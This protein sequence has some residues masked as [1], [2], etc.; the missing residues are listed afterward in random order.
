M[1]WNSC[2]P[3]T[4]QSKTYDQLCEIMESYYSEQK[5]EIA[6]RHT[7]YHRKQQPGESLREFLAELRKLSRH[8][9]FSCGEGHL[10]QSLRDSFV[11]GMTNATIQQRLLSERKLTL[12]RAVSL[13]EMLEAAATKAT[14]LRNDMQAKAVGSVNLVKGSSRRD[15]CSRCNSTEHMQQDCPLRNRKCHSC[16]KNGHIQSACRSKQVATQTGKLKQSGNARKAHYVE[17]SSDES[18]DLLTWNQVGEAI[19]TGHG[20]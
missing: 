8:C 17:S 19:S 3:G 16:G 15:K 11:F 7:F 14:L 2:A 1:L 6:E 13:G 20:I 10:N 12:E 18:D 9:N 5:I 4:P